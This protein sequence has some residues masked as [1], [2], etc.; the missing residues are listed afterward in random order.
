MITSKFTEFILSISYN[1]L[2]DS[3]TQKAKECFT[4]FLGVALRG[5]QSKSGEA[6]KNIIQPGDES[7]VMGHGRSSAMEAGLANGIFTHSM[8]LDDGHRMAMLHPGTCVIPA[9]LSLCESLNRSGKD[10]IESIVAGYQVAIALGMMINPRHRN[11]GF[12]STGTCGTLGAAAAASKAMN[13]ND[14]EITNALGLAGTQAAGLLESDHSGSMGKHLH[15]GRAAQ[16]GILSALLAKNGFTGA[17][18]IFEGDEGFLKVM[19][20]VNPQ[21]VDLSSESYNPVMNNYHILD[22]YF[23]IYPVCRHLHSSIDALLA[24][25]KKNQFKLE[26]IDEIMVK[27]YKIAAEHNDYHPTS[28][29]ALKQSLPVTLAVALLNHYQGAGCIIEFSNS[30]QNQVEIDDI[31]RKIQIKID[32]KLDKEYPHCR[33]SEVS[34]FTHNSVYK[35]RVDLPSGEPENPLKQGVDWKFRNLNPDVD[36][37]ILE[38]IENLDSYLDVR[39]FTDDLNSFL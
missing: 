30:T 35:K 21:E 33:P 8:D 6:V 2:P 10:L 27:T 7:T 5:S 34:I 31:S 38:V 9:A 11:K 37:E 16:S 22:V 36:V 15:A 1:Q 39:E 26:E 18:N 25:V 14:V 23:K 17:K 20:G 28:T 4:D 12:H 3:V 19:G 24:I 13:L 29:E 32:T